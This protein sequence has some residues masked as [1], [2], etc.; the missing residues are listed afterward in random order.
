[1]LSGLFEEVDA[2]NKQMTVR[3]ASHERTR[4]GQ[5]TQVRAGSQV[6]PRGLAL[7]QTRPQ[8]LTDE[9]TEL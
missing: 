1:M 9:R 4:R 2:G 7:P 5:S 3:Q 8:A 6:F